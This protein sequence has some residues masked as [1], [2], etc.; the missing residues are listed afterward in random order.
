MNLAGRGS[1]HGL[2]GHPDEYL[3][4]IRVVSISAQYTRRLTDTPHKRT[5]V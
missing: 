2:L 1:I 3:T 5:R 4:G